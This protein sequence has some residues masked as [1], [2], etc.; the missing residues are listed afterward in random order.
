MPSHI[1]R[2]FSRSFFF[3]VISANELIPVVEVAK[4]K[5]FPFKLADVRL[6]D[7]VIP[8]LRESSMTFKAAT[9][10]S[11]DHPAQNKPE[12]VGTNEHATP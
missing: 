4:V 2:P 11:R 6:P 12:S 3:A 9:T 10:S 1:A 7:P 5:L 8:V